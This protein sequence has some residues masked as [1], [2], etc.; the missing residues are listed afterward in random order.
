MD[1]ELSRGSV[2]NLNRQ[3]E[4]KMREGW[5]DVGDGGTYFIRDTMM[6]DGGSAFIEG[7]GGC[8]SGEEL[9]GG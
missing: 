8:N 2:V 4:M 5:T 7:V 6:G 3:K 1:T 9:P